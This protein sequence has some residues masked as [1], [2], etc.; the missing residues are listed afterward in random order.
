[1]LLRPYFKVSLTY[2]LYIIEVK[3]PF[4]RIITLWVVIR[5][6]VF[7]EENEKYALLLF[8]KFKYNRN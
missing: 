7:V 4:S 1:M 5:S 8:L 2:L 3:I 6:H